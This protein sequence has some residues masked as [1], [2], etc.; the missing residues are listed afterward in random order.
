MSIS[1]QRVYLIDGSSYIYRAYYAIRHLSNSKGEAT[2]AVY[3]FTEF[4]RE[5]IELEQPEYIACA[6]DANT[7]MQ[8]SFIRFL[9]IYICNTGNPNSASSTTR[10]HL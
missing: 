3:G 5:L 1:K 9:T 8:P 6:F 10:V 7:A 4:L 2:N